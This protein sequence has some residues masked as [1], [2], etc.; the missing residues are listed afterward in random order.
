MKIELIAYDANRTDGTDIAL[1]TAIYKVGLQTARVPA[2]LKGQALIDAIYAQLGID[3][4][5]DQLKQQWTDLTAQAASRPLATMSITE[6]INWINANVT[7]VSG[8]QT[9]LREL[10]KEVFLN[11]AKIDII[12]QALDYLFK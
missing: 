4:V 10:A 11:R 12:A 7:N 2:T 9:A 1:M 5:I 6:A 3:P 8:A